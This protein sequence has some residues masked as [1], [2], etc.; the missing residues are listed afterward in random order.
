MKFLNAACTWPADKGLQQMRRRREMMGQQNKGRFDAARWSVGDC[1]VRLPFILLS[2]STPHL[3]NR[4]PVLDG[5]SRKASH[6][7]RVISLRY[8]HELTED[9]RAKEAQHQWSERPEAG[10]A[11]GFGLAMPAL[12]PLRQGLP[13]TALS[14]SMYSACRSSVAPADARQTRIKLDLKHIAW[15]IA[16]CHVGHCW[17]SFWIFTRSPT[18]FYRPCNILTQV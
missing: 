14:A 15:F 5:E 1:R 12:L 8:S 13:M 6:Y 7:D 11:N 3:E 4:V 10:S 18:C 9:S 2:H 17:S 16:I